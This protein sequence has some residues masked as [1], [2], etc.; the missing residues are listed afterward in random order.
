MASTAGRHKGRSG[1]AS[2][3]VLLGVSVFLGRREIGTNGEMGQKL[4]LLLLPPLRMG[5]EECD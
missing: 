3:I 5:D 1:Q 4:D 2:Q